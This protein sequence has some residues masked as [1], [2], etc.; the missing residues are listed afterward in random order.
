MTI[1]FRLPVA[2]A[3]PLAYDAAAGAQPAARPNIVY[4]MSD[5]HAYQAISAYGSPLSKLAP[6]P[7]IDRIAKNGAIFTQSFVG[8]SLCGPS[9]ATLL[10][11]RQSHA[12]GFTQNGQRFDN[13][14]WVWP[15]ALGQAGY[16]TAMF[17]KWHINRSPEGIGFDDWKVLDDQG[18][19]Y[20]PDI[21]TP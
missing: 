13:K 5:Y 15:R 18:E 1:R 7:N 9:R 12:H 3:L 10:T 20:N 14:V 4:I 19:Y 21:I 2:L 11:G 17:G 16:A 6:T 8:N